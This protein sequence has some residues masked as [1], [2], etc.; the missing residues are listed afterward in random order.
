MARSR[1]SF[2]SYLR[3]AS[4]KARAVW[5]DALGIRHFRMLPGPFD[6]AESRAAFARFQLELETDP[7]RAARG[8]PEG[9]S[10]AEVL[11]AY[12]DHAGKHYR[13]AD[14]SPTSEIHE[15]KAVVKALRETYG[16]TPA[17]AFGPIG[18]KS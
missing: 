12:L 15:V 8:D 6:S 5:T 4:G 9:A 17:S 1:N 2:P 16:D 10:I 7:H 3:H 13:H 18:L 11:V 14:G